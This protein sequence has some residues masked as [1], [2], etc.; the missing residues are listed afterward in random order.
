M[1]GS[2][3]AKGRRRVVV[4]GIGLV[5]SLG[6][7]REASWIAL[8]QGR[9]KVWPLVPHEARGGGPTHHGFPAPYRDRFVEGFDPTPTLLQDC[10]AEAVA[11]AEDGAEGRLTA[12]PE[13]VAVLVGL[14]K[15][16]MLG[17]ERLHGRL[18]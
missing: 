17:L 7:G 18:V 13:R 11:D 12:D 2:T 3:I 16:R 10:L 5:T 14:S 9:V 1:K 4:T 8:R 15:G 6:R